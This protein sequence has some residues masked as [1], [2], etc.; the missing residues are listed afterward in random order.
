MIIYVQHERQYTYS[1][2]YTNSL[3][4][5][6]SDYSHS[7]IAKPY[8]TGRKR[9][10]MLLQDIINCHQMSYFFGTQTSIETGTVPSLLEP[11]ATSTGESV[12]N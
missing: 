3:R 1:I 10:L 2:A 11:Q 9:T 8:L 12:S 5:T 6:W 4:R 7:M